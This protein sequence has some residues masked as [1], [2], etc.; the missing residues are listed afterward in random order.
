M[1][2]RDN[3]TNKIWLY[4]IVCTGRVQETGINDQ[5]SAYLKLSLVNIPQN[6]ICSFMSL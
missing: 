2:I 6:Q 5:D 3:N 1:K 4:G